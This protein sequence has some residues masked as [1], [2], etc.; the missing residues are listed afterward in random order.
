MDN[1]RE[2][3]KELTHT[4]I[5]TFSHLHS[6]ALNNEITEE[7]AQLRAVSHIRNLW[8]GEDNKDYFWVTDMQPRMIVHPYRTDLEG[9]DM[10]GF[11]DRSDQP[12]FVKFVEIA[13]KSKSGYLT[14]TW[15]F[16]DQA[17]NIVPK[18][19][20]VQLFEPWGWIVGTGVYIEDVKAHIAALKERLTQI[21]VSITL[22]ICLL[23]LY[24]TRQSLRIEQQRSDYANDLSTANEKLKLSLR[25]LRLCGKN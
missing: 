4:A 8:Y 7:E 21:S 2:L 24:V 18:L 9:Q 3:I 5:S 12:I 15:Q 14:Y 17:D 13:Q 11:M 23:L 22:A 20:Y 10:S 19:S 16:K 25:S 1:K 6:Q